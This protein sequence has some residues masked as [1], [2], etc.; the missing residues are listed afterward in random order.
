[1]TNNTNRVSGRICS[2][3]YLIEDVDQ[4]SAQK[5]EI[6]STYGS[7][8]NNEN[9][10][11]KDI[12]S[13]VK[14]T[15]GDEFSITNV[16]I[17]RGSVVIEFTIIAGIFAT[18]VDYKSFVE[19]I[20][21]AKSQIDRYMFKKTG[22]NAQINS[23]WKPEKS[24]KNLASEQVGASKEFPFTA[25]LVWYVVLSHSVLLALVVFMVASEKIV[26]LFKL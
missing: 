21:L 25:V 22:N 24:L 4:E 20:Q 6:N 14:N 2:F 17:K 23:S 9:D 15:L 3:H 5:E 1:M 26:D 12:I 7:F 11:K 8:K 10:I 19:S 16:K 13:I 18:I